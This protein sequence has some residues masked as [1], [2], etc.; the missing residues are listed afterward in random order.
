MNRTALQTISE[1]EPLAREADVIDV[2]TVEGRVTLRQFIASMMGYYPD[3]IKALYRLRAVFVRLLGMRQEGI[4]RDVRL[5]PQDV[6][7]T[8]GSRVSFF[9]VVAAREEAL[10]LVEVHDQHLSAWLGVVVE[11]LPGAARRFHMVT[12]VKYHH[13]TGSLYFNVIRPF[14]HLVV[15]QMAHAGVKPTAML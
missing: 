7:M 9:A 10:W 13:W 12:L 1:F 14:H 15:R 2:K 5:R 3:W 4:P 11:E 6:P 8:P